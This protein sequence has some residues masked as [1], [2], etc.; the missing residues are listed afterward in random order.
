MASFS[1][2][3]PD[4]R[5]QLTLLNEVLGIAIIWLSQSTGT[6]IPEIEEI[7]L[8]VALEQV[9]T[10]EYQGIRPVMDSLD[11]VYVEF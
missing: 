11:D 8:D 2:L 6:P 3:S 9:E 1:D 4:K 5:Y 7:L 10:N